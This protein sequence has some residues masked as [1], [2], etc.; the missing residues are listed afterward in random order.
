MSGI[1]DYRSEVVGLYARS[2]HRP[3]QYQ[4]YLKSPAIRQRYWARN[5]VGWPRFCTRL[6]NSAHEFI[7]KL[8]HNYD[9]VSCIITQN[10]DRLHQKAGSTNVIELHG[11]AFRVLCLDCKQSF[12]RHTV[13]EHMRELNPTVADTT[14]MIRPDGDVEIPVV[15]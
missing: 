9:K 6:P 8:E 15:S 4:D 2:N 1:P 7:S 5:Y 13:Q 14:T 11:S 10:V 3:V 12:D